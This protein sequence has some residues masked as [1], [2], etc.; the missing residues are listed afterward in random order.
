MHTSA[1]VLFSGGQD[2][3]TCLA[4]ALSRY[5][6]VETIAF[7]YRQRHVVE[8]D[9]RLRV[10]EELRRTYPHWASKLGQDHLLDVA[11]LGAVSETSLTRET[12]FQMQANGLPNTFVPGRNLLF[13]TLAAAVAYRRDL[14]VLV[15]GVCETDFSG[16][17]DCRDDTMKAM[18][19]ALSLGMDKRLLIE[20]P[21]MWIDKADT[22]RLAESLGGKALVDLIVEH[23]HTCYLGE[24]DQRHAWGY[25]C[26]RC[27]ACELRAGGWERYR[28][29]A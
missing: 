19:L 22:W 25:G 13:L 20:T 5:E 15:T 10:L 28:S 11:V 29:A 4:H 8:L 12:E 26:G 18:Q 9:A 17:P 7:D 27:P 21:L 3:T 16:Y 2:S 24:R 23:T 1:L 6:R 14:Q